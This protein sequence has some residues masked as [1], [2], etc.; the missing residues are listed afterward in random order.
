MRFTAPAAALAMVLAIGASV[1]QSADRVT[2]PRAAALIAEGRG[3]L[4]AGQ[5]EKAVD[6]FESALAIDPGATGVYLDLA[7][8]ARRNGLQGK[9]IRYYRAALERDPQNLAALSGEG[10]ALV[11]KGAVEKARRNLAKLQTMCGENCAETRQLAAAIAQ[12]PQARVL[13]AEAVLPDTVVT[14][15]N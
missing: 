6:A 3:A 14:Q 10:A 4:A 7:E 5:P 12:G 13:T 1:G 8:A 9:A 2:D 11:E 15:K